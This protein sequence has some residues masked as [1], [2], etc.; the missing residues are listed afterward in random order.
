MRRRG[1]WL[2]GIAIVLA[3]LAVLCAYLSF[4]DP[5]G[6]GVTWANVERI[7][8]GMTQPEVEA[9]VGRPPQTCSRGPGPISDNSPPGYHVVLFWSGMECDILVYLDRDGRVIGRE[10]VGSAGSGPLAWYDRLRKRVGL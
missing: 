2:A 6:P 3:G 5:P 8:V 7:E 1:Y 9:V 4:P 10:G